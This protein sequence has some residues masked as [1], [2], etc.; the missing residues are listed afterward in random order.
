VLL[1]ALVLVYSAFATVLLEPLRGRQEALR[2]QVEAT[3]GQIEALADEAGALARRLAEAPDAEL[4]RESARLARD[5]ADFD[6]RLAEQR[7]GLVE[8]SQMVQLLEELLERQHDLRLVRLEA[9]PAAAVLPDAPP[10]ADAAGSTPARL[11]RHEVVLEFEGGYLAALGYLDALRELPWRIYWD[12][13]HYEVG[14]HPTA[15][16]TLRVHTLSFDEAWIGV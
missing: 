2:T 1:A 15:H 10:G 9:L 14:E 5:I 16:V 8:P 4:R 12:A 3:A 13:L 6:A 11:F 7:L